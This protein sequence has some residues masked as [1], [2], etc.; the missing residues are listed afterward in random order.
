MHIHPTMSHHQAHEQVSQ[1]LAPDALFTQYLTVVNR[2]IAEN[3]DG[4]YG[5]AAKLWD[6]AAGDE[7]VAVGVYKSDAESPHHWYTV[8]IQ[9]GRVDLVDAAKAN[10]AKQSWKISDEHLANVVDNPDKYVESPF[11][12][13]LDWLATR[14]GLA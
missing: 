6:K 8:T 1:D 4:L 13:D 10:D 9:D 14:V 2:V 12:L 5:K 3:R 7:K 11:K